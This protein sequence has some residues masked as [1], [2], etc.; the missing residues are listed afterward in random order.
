MENCYKFKCETCRNPMV[1]AGSAG[2]NE[3]LA[4]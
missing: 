3:A 2:A 4:E 1:K